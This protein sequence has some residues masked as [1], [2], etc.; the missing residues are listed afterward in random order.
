[1]KMN[2]R[3]TPIVAAIFLLAIA[4]GMPLHAA[5]IYKWVDENGVVHFS[6]NPPPPENQAA[7]KIAVEDSR[8][9]DWDPEQDIYGVEEQ[10]ARMQAMR[11]DMETKRQDRL[12]RQRQQAAMQP[13]PQPREQERYG[14]PIYWNNNIWPRPPV[15]PQPPIARPEPLPGGPGDFIR[16]PKPITPR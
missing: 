1:M 13:Q 12:E 6:D 8:P 9:S 5:E 16:P 4:A 10:A 14:Y 7:E 2:V 3:P 15:R 11:E